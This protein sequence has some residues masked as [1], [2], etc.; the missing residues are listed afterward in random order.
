MKN[1]YRS[2]GWKQGQQQQIDPVFEVIK[3]YIPRETFRILKGVSEERE[4]PV[5]RLAAIAIDN[6]LDQNPSFNYPCE[7]PTE[8]AQEFAY[9]DQAG[10][11]MKYLENFPGGTSIDTLML[12]RRD[13]GIESRAVLMN[14]VQ[15]LLDAG[16][17]EQFKPL[18][19]KFRYSKD[20]RR[21]RIVNTDP[22]AIKKNRYKRHG[23]DD[24]E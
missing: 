22:K 7:Y 13:M 9:A 11:V 12:C 17:I 10:E 2:F 20:Y 21:L 1:H 16:L 24:E 8:K 14:A 18:R 19:T 23:V 3:V 6:E 5:S 4:I 15:E